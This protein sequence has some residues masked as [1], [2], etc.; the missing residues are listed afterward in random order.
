MN[1]ARVLLVLMLM[2]PCVF[3]V[4][5]A[6]PGTGDEPWFEGD[7]RYP[8]LESGELD[9]KPPL[10]DGETRT[11]AHKLPLLAQEVIDRGFELPLPYGAGALLGT[12]E[13]DVEVANLR[14]GLNGGPLEALDWVGFGV[15]KASH[16]MLQTKFDFWLLPFLNVFVA[17]GHVD[18]STHFPVSV[19]GDELLKFLLPDLGRLC[20]LVPGN[21]LR[22]ELC[23]QTLFATAAPD[24]SGETLALGTNLALGWRQFFAMANFTYAV[25]EIDIV[26]EDIEGVTASARIGVMTRIGSLG[27]IAWY[28]GGMYLDTELD[29]SGTVQIPA[30]QAPDIGDD[31]LLEFAITQK[32]RD[33]WNYLAGFNWDLSARWMINFEA[34]FGGSR[35]HYFA[36]ATWRF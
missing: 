22:P 27:E 34:G 18:G 8:L 35:K 1:R 24:F 4:A 26:N 36:G 33:K 23:D 2:L 28:G 16:D 12:I 7:I 19:P 25:S 5:T 21:P 17:A 9:E 13:Q 10:A 29:L 3:R 20:D 6:A 11:W 31:V 14:V 32:N 15:G 30:H